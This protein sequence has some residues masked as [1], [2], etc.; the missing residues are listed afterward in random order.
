MATRASVSVVTSTGMAG[1]IGSTEAAP[2]AAPIPAAV[3]PAP[4]ITMSASSSGVLPG[5]CRRS[6][7]ASRTGTRGAIEITCSDIQCPADRA[8][9]QVTAPLLETL[10][11]TAASA[12]RCRVS[13][14]PG[15]SR[16]SSA[17]C[18]ARSDP[19]GESGGAG[20]GACGGTDSVFP[21]RRRTLS[22]NLLM[23][24]AYPCRPRPC[25]SGLDRRAGGHHP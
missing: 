23:A 25:A 9:C 3:R 13:S 7:A 19:A 1:I 20:G 14:A 17:N 4:R 18:P 16:A 10:R 21:R 11:R 6:V 22:R 2:T 24:Q 5:Y 8:P 15:S 12:R